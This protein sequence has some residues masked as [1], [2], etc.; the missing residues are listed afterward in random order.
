MNRYEAEKV[1]HGGSH[2]PE[3][4]LMGETQGYLDH[5]TRW[6]LRYLLITPCNTY[7]FADAFADGELAE[8]LDLDL[9]CFDADGTIPD[10]AKLRQMPRSELRK[11]LR[12]R[13]K[14]LETTSAAKTNPLFQNIDRLTERLSLTPAAQTLLAFAVLLESIP[15]L[16][17]CMER[18]RCRISNQEFF[19]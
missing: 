18:L 10:G 12:S 11:L 4:A 1:M 16:K 3:K 14:Q 2:E 19:P 6:A 8:A 9:P 7:R 5:C 17:R 13:L 15:T